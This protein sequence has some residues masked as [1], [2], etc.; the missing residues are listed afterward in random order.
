VG[1]API[2]N[3]GYIEYAILVYASG[4]TFGPSG[5]CIAEIHDAV[6]LGWSRYDRLPGKAFFTLPQ[7]SPLISTVNIVTD[8]NLIADG[9]STYHVE[10]WR[11]TTAGAARVFRGILMDTDDTG[12]DVVYSAY[13]YLS[14]LSLSR[15]AFKGL[16]P[17]KLLGTEIVA[18]E[19]AAALAV[20]SSL[21]GF[22][23]TGTIEDPV[24]ID[25]ST[26]IKTNAQ[27]GTIDQ[28]RLQLFFDISEMGR[29]NTGYRVTFEI[30]DGL[31]FNFWKNKI[32]AAPYELSL[33][34]TV[35][36]YEFSPGGTHY[37]NDLA[38]VGVGS[39]GG[40]SELTAVGDAVSQLHTMGRRQ[41][42]TPLKTLAGISAGLPETDQMQAAL[43]QAL[44][45]AIDYPGNLSV[46]VERGTIA[47]DVIQ[48]NDIVPCEIVNGRDALTKSP[49]V[50][51]ERVL[52][53]ESGEDVD[54]LLAYDTAVVIVGGGG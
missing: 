24:G 31:A 44:R 28:S 8:P 36:D 15:S 42:V 43:E 18:P 7:T 2:G 13:D 16:Y 30:T 4:S 45:R 52:Y 21:V 46:R 54:L 40:A 29:A 11:I 41:D 12:D 50:V 47:P 38:T 19:W 5:E 6:N 9:P 37:R 22:V 33:N 39:T 32:R 14:L 25:G 17:N 3:T 10:F 48:M 51:G 20:G 34:G 26:A 35:T 23:S 53:D 27:F 49:F 1:S